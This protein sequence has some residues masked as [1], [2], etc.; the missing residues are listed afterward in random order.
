MAPYKAKL[1]E[2][3]KDP[4]SAMFKSLRVV[5]GKGGEALCG[6]VNAKNSYGGYTGFNRF[7][8]STKKIN[9]SN[10]DLAILRESDELVISELKRMAY[11]DVGCQDLVKKKKD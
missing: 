2:R 4:D 5:E 1:I 3:L 6:E 9:H 10:M 7:F 11:E 8:V